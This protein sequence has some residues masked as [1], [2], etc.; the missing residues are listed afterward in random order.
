[1]VAA[2]GERGAGVVIEARRGHAQAS[3]QRQEQAAQVSPS[4]ISHEKKA[5]L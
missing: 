1:M 5:A 3:E 4:S 2:K